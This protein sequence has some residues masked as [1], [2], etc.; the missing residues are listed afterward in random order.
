MEFSLVILLGLLAVAAGRGA[1]LKPKLASF[2]ERLDG[3]DFDS[4][5]FLAKQQA[6]ARCRGWYA[7]CGPRG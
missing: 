1:E 7:W 2:Q 5:Q 3:V 4:P 6:A